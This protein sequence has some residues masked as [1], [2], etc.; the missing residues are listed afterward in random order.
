M[1]LTKNT[2][3][4]MSIASMMTFVG[5][6]WISS[7]F[8]QG[9]IGMIEANAS[10]IAAVVLSLDISRVDRMIEGLKKERRELRRRLRETPN[11]DLLHEQLEELDDAISHQETIRQC[12]VNPEQRICQ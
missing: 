11:N 1:M 8:I 4:G 7:G 5:A 6:I 9:K 12:V 10:A 3:W 2:M